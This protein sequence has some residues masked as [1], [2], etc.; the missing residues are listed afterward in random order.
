MRLVLLLFIILPIVEMWILIEVGQWIGAPLTIAAVLATALAGAALLRREGLSTLSRANERM[1]RGELPASEMLE[2]VALAIGG[3]LLLTPGFVTDTVGF[4]CLL[5]FTR[6]AVVAW[7][8]RNV[9]LQVMTAGST[10]YTS[11]SQTDR[12]SRPDVIEGEYER[13][14]D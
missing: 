10:T 13:K 2:G 11:Y 7:L 8:L 3:A 6:R 9:P 1:S 12:S 14:D 4:T 5:P